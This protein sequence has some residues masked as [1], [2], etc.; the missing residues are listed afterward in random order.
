MEKYIHQARKSRQQYNWDLTALMNQYGVKTETEMI[1]GFV[2]T[3]LKR[4]NKKSDYDVQKQTASAVETMRK[5]W[6]SNFLKEFVDLPVDT[7]VKDKRKRIATKIAA[8]YYV[9]YHPT[10]RAR[11]LSVEGSYFS[12]PWVM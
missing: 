2:I 10:E 12:F 3:W 4:G 5:L 8:W 1:S 11:D 9:T 6:R 7:M